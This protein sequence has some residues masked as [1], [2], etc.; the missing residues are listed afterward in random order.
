MISIVTGYY[1]RK[2][3]FYRTLKSITRSEYKDIELIAV[4]DGSS[5]EH[6]IEDLVEEFPFLKIIRLEKEDKWYSNPCITFNIGIRA[7]K[8]DIIVLQNPECLHVHD[9]LT[10]VSQNVNDTNYITM[11]AYGVNKEINEKISQNP[12]MILGIF[13][14]LPQRPYAGYESIGWYNHSKY[15][16]VYYHFCSAITRSNMEKLN[17][18]DERYAKGIGYD[19]DEIIA[20]ISKLGLQLMINDNISVIHQYHD[21]VSWNKPNA[22]MLTER[23]RL[24]LH[25]ITFKENKYSANFIK[26][27][28][29]N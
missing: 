15:R 13:N 24:I 21:T 16:R 25:N 18:F 8:G 9:V 29:G 19:D 26:L 11:S 22:D 10:Y 5:P 23:N 6:R 14:S 28:D 17:G 1:N 3:L 20:R 2:D 4:D 12:D 7:S 27:W